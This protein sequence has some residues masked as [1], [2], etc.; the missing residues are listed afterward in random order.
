MKIVI[1][2]EEEDVIDAIPRL[3]KILRACQWDGFVV[4]VTLKGKLSA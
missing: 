2:L 1:E 3:T 4:E